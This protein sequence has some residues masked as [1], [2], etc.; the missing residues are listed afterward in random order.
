[1][2][3]EKDKYIIIE[4]IPTALTK[5]KG[6]LI[7]V[8]ALKV[9]NLVI[10]SRFDYRINEDKILIPDFKEMI[11]Y[12]K[13]SFKYKETTEEILKDLEEWIEDYPLL[14]LDNVYTNNF[15]K[16]INNKKESIAKL[17]DKEYTDT[18]I[19][20]LIKENNLEPSNYI[21]DLLYESIIKKI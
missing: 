7:Q 3:L 17:L 15:L 1:M 18:L 9:N 12:D 16:G 5:E 10:E 6:D 2:N 21:V 19:D 13:E 20:D 8:S 4:L 11:S 14:I